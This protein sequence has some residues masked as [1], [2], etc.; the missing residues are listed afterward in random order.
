MLEG[1]TQE[2]L[3]L[4][5]EPPPTSLITHPTTHLHIQPGPATLRTQQ[6]STDD[7]EPPYC[8][9]LYGSDSEDEDD[10]W[11]SERHIPTYHPNPRSQSAQDSLLPSPTSERISTGTGEEDSDPTNDSARTHVTAIGTV[12]N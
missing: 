12:I 4:A 10:T 6:E 3:T 7:E 5:T 1:T 11:S 9:A 8:I 2:T